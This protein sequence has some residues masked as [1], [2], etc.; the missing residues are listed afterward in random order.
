MLRTEEK[1]WTSCDYLAANGI[2]CV[3]VGIIRTNPINDNIA[4]FVNKL[5]QQ[6]GTKKSPAL[7]VFVSTTAVNIVL[8]KQLIWPQNVEVIAVGKSTAAELAKGGIQAHV[9]DSQN[10]EGLLAMPQLQDLAAKSVFLIKGQGG[11]ALLLDTLLQR[12]ADVNCFDL[13][14]R[15][16][17][18]PYTETR[19]WHKHEITSIVATSG[20]IMQAAWNSF[21]HDWLKSLPWIVVSQRLGE[22]AAKLGIEQVVQSAG[23]SNE[24]LQMAISHFWSNK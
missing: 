24:Q 16:Q 11:R 9:P 6:T 17:C 5:A 23:A 12:G 1:I 18:N 20:E 10:T 8:E 7:A 14:E 13:Y 3:G 22:L 15:S 21:N 2:E 4:E 19:S